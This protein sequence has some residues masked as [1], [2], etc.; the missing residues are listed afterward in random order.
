MCF[1]RTCGRV[2][3]LLAVASSANAAVFKDGERAA[4]F[5]DSCTHHGCWV[6]PLQDFYYTRFPDAD[7]RIWNCGVGGETSEE[8]SRRIVADVAW[9]KPTFV[10]VSFGMN[11]VCVDGYKTNA[12]TWDVA[13][14]KDALKYF[15]A[16]MR[17]IHRIL[18][19]SAPDARICWCTL[20]PWD[21]ELRFN[22]PR[23]SIKGV[24]EGER[25]LS[26]FVKTFH[27]EVGGSFVDFYG[28]MLAYNRK[29]HKTDPF[30]S[31][32]PDTIHPQEPGG[33]FML[34]LFLKAQGMNGVVSDVML[35]A[36]T[37]KIV[38]S[39]NAQVDAVK[40]TVSGGVSFRV[41]EK[42]L[43]FPVEPRAR[44]MA[45]EIGFDEAFNREI[46]RVKGLPGGNWTLFIDGE[47]VQ[48]ESAKVWSDGVNLAMIELT[49]M[50]KQARKVAA[51]NADKMEKE[52]KIRELWV[53]RTIAFRRMEWN[54]KFTDDD[55]A[56]SRFAESYITAYLHAYERSG[57][58][59]ESDYDKK[60]FETF[61]QDWSSVMSREEEIERIHTE[62]RGMCVPKVHA[63]EFVRGDGTL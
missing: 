51:C 26:D 49:P 40:K 43:P 32:S 24:T 57:A 22:P 42:A 10:N 63:Y 36:S 21:D 37:C 50:M 45:D 60:L 18:R 35:D 31:L 20:V 29:L 28:P 48:T 14:R 25:P 11:D 53:A 59:A 56:D 46:L 38:R 55:Y 9:R 41:R 44:A 58:S 6:K 19:A 13:R 4:F 5:G 54:V 39:T 17:K 52:K 61:K 62:I 15:E 34:H 1:I 30:S 27:K 8:G 2:A 33:L 16:G 12:P 47:K 3:C 23:E 7:I